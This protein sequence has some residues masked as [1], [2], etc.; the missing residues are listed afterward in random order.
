[1]RRQ[2]IS[3]L[4]ILLLWITISVAQSATKP[5][6]SPPGSA[7]VSD[8]RK[9]DFLSFTYPSSLCSQEFGK[10]GIGKSVHVQ[11]GEFKNK[12]VYFAVEDNRILYGDVTGDGSEEAIVPASCGA[13]TANFSRAEIYIYTLKAGRPVLVAAISDKDMERDYRRSYPDA[14][15][16]WGITGEGLQIRNSHLEIE[17][18]ADGSH[19][20]PKYTVKLEYGLSGKSFRLLGKPQRKNSSQ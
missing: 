14:E 15:S 12:Q 3:C 4:V 7:T 16:Y 2:L 1:M 17:V 20:S 5:K 10:K 11:K 13:I 19:A 8:I 6:G 9:V 18:V